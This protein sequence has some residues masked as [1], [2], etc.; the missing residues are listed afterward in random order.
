[1]IIE[2]KFLFFRSV[3]ILYEG[4]NISS[5]LDRKRYDYAVVVSYEPL[6]LPANFRL[7]KKKAANIRLNG[8]SE[9]IFGRFSV[10]TRNE[11]HKTRKIDELE[12]KIA[13]ENFKDSYDLYCRFEKEQSR[14]PWSVETYKNT[15][16]FNAYYKGEIIVSM[17]CF[18][19]QPYLQIRS[20]SSKR[21]EAHDAAAG[22]MIGYASRRLIY[23]ICRYGK[24][25]GYEFAGLGAVNYSTSQKTGVSDFKMFFAPE[26][27][28]EYTYTY[29]SGLFRFLKIL[30][31]L[32]NIF[33][34]LTT[35]L[36]QR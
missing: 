22:K 7:S 16:L 15:I 1:M 33:L 11:I 36:K 23:E 12:F 2:K 17:P 34:K 21:L 26:I 10:S 5:L 29:E 9:E 27:G 31:P 13:D 30:L 28:D 14:A 3:R 24:E 20:I 35:F 32:K 25:K 4:E 6:R 8:S 18:N 19:L